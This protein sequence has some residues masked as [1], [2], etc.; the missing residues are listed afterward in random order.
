MEIVKIKEDEKTLLLEAKGEDFTLFVPLSE[1]L[2][3][4]SG[5]KESAV[6]REHPYLSEPQ[7]WVKVSRGKPLE[8]IKKASEKLIKEIGELKE[9]FKKSLS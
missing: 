8:A 4:I 9:K 1:K 2:W 5:V 6:I 7:L 3:E